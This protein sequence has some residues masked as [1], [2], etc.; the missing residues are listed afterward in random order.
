[1][2]TKNSKKFNY[3]IL[4]CIFIYIWCGIFFVSSFSIKDHGSRSFPQV[5]CILAFILATGFLITCLIGK[6]KEEL[7]FSGTGRAMIMAALLLAYMLGCN[8]LGF[9]VATVIYL[10]I[11]MWYLG[12]RNKKLIA[13][14]SIALPVFVY[15]VFQKLLTMQ[16]PTGIFH[17]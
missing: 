12:Q 7:D 6:N 11:A 5:I 3:N 17:R 16:I 4:S 15:F 10:P 14:I 8:T 2:D 9:Y 13:I 1:M